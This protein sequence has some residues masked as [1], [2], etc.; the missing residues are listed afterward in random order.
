VLVARDAV[1]NDEPLLIFNADT[2]CPTTI[3]RAVTTS[4]SA[5]DGVLDVFRA[6]GDRWSFARL[7][8]GDRVLE[9]AEKRRISEWASTGLYYFRRG[10]DFVRH[11]TAMI[12]ADERSDREFY[13]APVYNRL[14]AAGADV[15]ANRVDEVWVLGTPKD[16][17]HFQREYPHQPACRGDREK[18][19]T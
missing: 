16:L 11:A 3:G 9:T 7:D 6:A 18:Y 13:V 8:E 2:Y 17:A 15:R 4:L 5:A 1:D 10:L 12:D 19:C 14:I